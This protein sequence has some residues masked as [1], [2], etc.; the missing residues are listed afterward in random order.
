MDLSSVV[1]IGFFLE[2]LLY[3]LLVFYCGV[4]IL[5]NELAEMFISFLGLFVFSVVEA[6]QALTLPPS[7]NFSPSNFV[8][9]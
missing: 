2:Y 5:S 9:I 6:K 8:F 3:L 7:S 4:G 1:F